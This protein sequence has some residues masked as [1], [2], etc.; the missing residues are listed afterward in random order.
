MQQEIEVGKL[1]ELLKVKKVTRNSNLG[2]TQSKQDNLGSN[3]ARISV[4]DGAV[5]IYGSDKIFGEPTA[6]SDMILD[7]ED[8]SGVRVFATVPDYI[9]LTGTSTK[10]AISG[11]I[12]EKVGEFA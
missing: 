10:V 1:Y 3:E 9:Y 5:D 7:Q 2:S 11:A 6:T 8:F 4:Y 12:Y